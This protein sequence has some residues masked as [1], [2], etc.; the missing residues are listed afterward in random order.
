MGEIELEGLSAAV[1]HDPLSP[2]PEPQHRII[3]RK[4]DHSISLVYPATCAVP[5]SET[6]GQG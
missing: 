1:Q 3:A 5:T 4:T 6:P 2:M